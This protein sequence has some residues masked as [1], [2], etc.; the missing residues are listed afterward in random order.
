MR[1]SAWAGAGA[2]AEPGQSLWRHSARAPEYRGCAR[3]AR[4][5]A[6]ALA[7]GARTPPSPLPP[8]QTPPA[9]VRSQC[10]AMGLYSCSACMTSRSATSLLAGPV[11]NYQR[12]PPAGAKA[13]RSQAVL[14]VE[15]RHATC[16]A[17]FMVARSES[18]PM[19]MPT[20]GAAAPAPSSPRPAPHHAFSRIVLG[21]ITQ[22][23]QL[24]HPPHRPCM[25]DMGVRGLGE[26]RL[27]APD[28][29]ASAAAAPASIA[30]S[31]RRASPGLGAV[32]V[33]WPTCECAKRRRL[34]FY[35]LPRSQ[36]S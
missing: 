12:Q 18:E 3:S 36:S 21:V 17:A 15:R 34:L 5:P 20:R 2:A 25:G 26:V 24:L 30:A 28:V 19:M 4:S 10:A 16:A 31:R 8:P 29:L 7:C 33:T 11:S 27:S 22:Q 13:S 14:H 9:P 23:R 32:M 1:T 6:C 35:T